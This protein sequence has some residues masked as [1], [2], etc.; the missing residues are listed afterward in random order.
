MLFSYLDNFIHIIYCDNMNKRKIIINVLCLIIWTIMIILIVF[1]KTNKDTVLV[2]NNAN[3]SSTIVYRV[4]DDKILYQNIYFA[5]KKRADIIMET[6]EIRVSP[7]K[8]NE[9]Y[10]PKHIKGT[11]NG[12]F[13]AF[14]GQIFL[15]ETYLYS[16]T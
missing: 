15:K 7:I 3:I 9:F 11:I 5:S 6:K 1:S 13:S 8:D 16:A 12:K 10:I 4:N 2:M 14:F